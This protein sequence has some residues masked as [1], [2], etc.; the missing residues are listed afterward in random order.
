MVHVTL[1]LPDHQAQH[2]AHITDLRWKY[3]CLYCMYISNAVPCSSLSEWYFKMSRDPPL[4][5]H[6]L[7][8]GSFKSCRENPSA[9]LCRHPEAQAAM[10]PV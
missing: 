2:S 3:I 7:L 5:C 6:S 9:A 1:H 10:A 8:L 4:F